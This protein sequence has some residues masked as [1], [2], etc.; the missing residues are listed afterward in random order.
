MRKNYLKGVYDAAIGMIRDSIGN[1]KIWVYIDGSTDQKGRF[2]VNIVIG[3]LD[4]SEPTAPYL[5]DC[6]IVERSNHATVPQALH[7]SLTIL[8]PNG[9][10]HDRLLLFVSDA[11]KYMKKAA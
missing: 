3:R 9:I 8:W 11:A 7:D 10:K 2:V 1:S 4:S 6:R 5:L